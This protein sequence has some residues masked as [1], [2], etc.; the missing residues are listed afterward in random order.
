MG[1]GGYGMVGKLCAPIMSKIDACNT[2]IIYFVLVYYQPVKQKMT[3]P[4]K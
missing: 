1:D 2:Y 3:A 4:V